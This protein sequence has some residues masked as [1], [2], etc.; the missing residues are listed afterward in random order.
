MASL[1][2]NECLVKCGF[3]ESNTEFITTVSLSRTLT[4]LIFQRTQWSRHR[5]S[6]G[7]SGKAPARQCR[8]HKRHGFDPWVGKIPWRRKWHPLQYSFLGN[9]KDRGAWWATV[10]GVAKSQ[11]CLSSHARAHRVSTVVAYCMQ[12]EKGGVSRLRRVLEAT[13]LVR[14]SKDLNPMV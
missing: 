14:Q 13:Q 9:P 8:R 1:L 11:T 10:H 4:H 5:L 7:L 3:N 12:E 6:R 2:K